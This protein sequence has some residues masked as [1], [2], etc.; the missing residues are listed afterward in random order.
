MIILFGTGFL[1][2]S[3]VTGGAVGFKCGKRRRRRRLSGARAG[4]GAAR[5]INPSVF[6]FFFI[7]LHAPLK[8]LSQPR[9]LVLIQPVIR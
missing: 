7:P 4:G 1:F 3:G 6:N 5:R 2:G 9:N 8:N